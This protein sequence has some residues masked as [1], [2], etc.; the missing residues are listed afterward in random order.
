MLHCGFRIVGVDYVFSVPRK[1][2]VVTHAEKFHSQNVFC[3]I[4]QNYTSA[5]NPAVHLPMFPGERLVL[6]TLGGIST[7]LYPLN[8]I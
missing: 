6:R 3:I 7:Q 4:I 8:F 5:H 1:R 2:C